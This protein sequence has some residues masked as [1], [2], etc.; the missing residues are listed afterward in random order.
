MN[1][2]TWPTLWSPTFMSNYWASVTYVLEQAAPAIM[3][4]FAIVTVGAIAVVTVGIFYPDRS[5][6]DYE[7][8]ED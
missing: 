8:E 6:N 5:E 1:P 2:S 7:E 4:G 3:I